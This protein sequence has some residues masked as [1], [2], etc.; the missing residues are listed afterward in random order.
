[1]GCTYSVVAEPRDNQ[2]L[3]IRRQNICITHVTVNARENDIL[4]DIVSIHDLYHCDSKWGRVVT[5]TFRYIRK[6]LSDSFY[7]R[8]LGSQCYLTCLH[9]SC[10]V[11]TFNV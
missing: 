9:A 6:N 7:G 10:N 4:F 5:P 1:M 11:A 3:F 8:G 2:L